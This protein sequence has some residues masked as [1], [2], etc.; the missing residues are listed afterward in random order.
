MDQVP[1]QVSRLVKGLGPQVVGSVA[2]DNP[3]GLAAYADVTGSR[4]WETP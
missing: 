2:S 4:D 1:S 3:L